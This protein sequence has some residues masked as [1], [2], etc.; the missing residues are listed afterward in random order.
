M[1]LEETK[2]R[3]LEAE[4]VIVRAQNAL[5]PEHPVFW[6]L[7]DYDG[8]MDAIERLKA[9]VKKYRQKLTNATQTLAFNRIAT[10]AAGQEVVRLRKELEELRAEIQNARDVAIQELRE[11]ENRRDAAQGGYE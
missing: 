11:A 1:D 4:A 3:L 10:D 5:T 2:N 7:D 8:S 6:V 9:D